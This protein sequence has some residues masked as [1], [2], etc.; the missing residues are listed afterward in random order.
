MVILFIVL[1]NKE[2]LYLV[3]TIVGATA[4]IFLAKGN[5]VGIILSIAFSVFYSVVAITFRYY[6][7][8]I[9]YFGMTLPIEIISLIQW[10]RHPF[11]G[12][13]TEVEIVKLKNEEYLYIV[14]AGAVVTILFYFILKWLNT[15]NLIFAT[16]S[17]F[18]SF[19][20]AILSLKRSRFYAIAYALNDIVLIILWTLATLDDLSYLAIVIC[21]VS[22]FI[23]DVYAFI[24]WTK[25]YKNQRKEMAYD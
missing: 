13:K 8:I 21:F 19:V 25:M 15:S 20:A 23:N 18:T 5:L 11:K 9:T 22:F 1:K 17:I 14:V 6:S 3:T 2:W 4:L 16:I 24:N 12:E 10:I 7:E